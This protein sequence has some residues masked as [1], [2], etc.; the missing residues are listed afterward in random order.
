MISTRYRIYQGI[1]MTGLGLFILFTGLEGELGLYASP[2]LNL[3]L[4]L[5]S[6]LILG[7]AQVIFQV[8]AKDV[9]ARSFLPLEGQNTRLWWFILPVAVGLLLTVH[10]PASRFTEVNGILLQQFPERRASPANLLMEH[11]PNRRTIRDWL[12]VYGAAPDREAM[13]GQPIEVTGVVHYDQRISGDVF[14]LYRFVTGAGMGDSYA[15]GIHVLW[16]EKSKFEEGDWVQVTGTLDQ[17]GL[18]WLREPVPIIVALEVENAQTPLQAIE[19]L[20]GKPIKQP[21]FDSVNTREPHLAY[22]YPA[23]GAANLWYNSVDGV[24]KVQ[25]THHESGVLTYDVSNDGEAI[26]YALPNEEDGVDLWVWDEKNQSNVLV[27][28]GSSVCDQPVWE[29]AGQLIAYSHYSYNK[30]SSN[31]VNEIR[32]LDV[33]TH[34]EIVVFQGG[35]FHET[36][37]AWSSIGLQLSCYDHSQGHIRVFNLTNWDEVRIHSH[38]ISSGAWLPGSGTLVVPDFT[39]LAGEKP[40]AALFTANFENEVLLPFNEKDLQAVDVGLP[41][42]SPDGR[43]LI[44][45]LG[46]DGATTA[47]GLWIADRDLEEIV[48]L[49][50]NPRYIHAAYAWHPSGRSIVFQRYDLSAGFAR[51]EVVLWQQGNCEL[52]LLCGEETVIAEDAFLPMWL[53]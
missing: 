20:D 19:Y 45:G 6:V 43:W 53:P 22:L 52:P 26:V 35:S 4:L 10:H 24:D 44:L 42:F 15:V 31:V 8:R 5:T 13:T 47:R 38:V 21:L 37:C 9:G 32:L 49:T 36:R 17:F 40:Q 28:C 41:E 3:F 33:V 11:P 2:R 16:P 48:P 34:E 25:L 14:L 46:F 23:S 51:P 27:S 39:Y 30:Q 50:D 12:M 7:L 1:A 29:P 18:P